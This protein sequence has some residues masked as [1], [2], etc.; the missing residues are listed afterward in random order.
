MVRMSFGR[1]KTAILIIVAI[2]ALALCGLDIAMLA[3]APG[4]DNSSPAVAS[5][6]LCAGILILVACLL[7]LLNSYYKFR[8]KDYIAVLGFFVDKIAYDRILSVQQNSKTGE[9]YVLIEDE[10]STGGMLGLKINV[11]NKNTDA[12][13]H[14]LLEKKS[15]LTVEFFMPESND[16]KKDK[17]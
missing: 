8:D 15:D 17:K 3:G 6:S 12:F 9:L 16:G 2:C 11:P 1:W 14:C 13:L 10:K 7:V 4:V 5:V